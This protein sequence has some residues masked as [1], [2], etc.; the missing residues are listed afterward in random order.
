M[1]FLAIVFTLL[2]VGSLCAQEVSVALSKTQARVGETVQFSVTV[3][4]VNRIEAPTTIP[5]NGLRINFAGQSSQVQ[6]Q[7]FQMSSSATVTYLVVPQFEG[8]FTIPAFDLRIR[9][10]TLATSPIQLTVSGMASTPS[11]P[12][13]PQSAPSVPRPQGGVDESQPIYFGELIL[14]KPSAFVGEV[15]PAELRFYF[16]SGIGGQIGERPSF[17]GEGFTIEKFTQGARRDQI[18]NGVGYTVFTFKTAITA[19]KTGTLSLP[20]ATLDA[21]LQLPGQPSQD[22]FLGQFQGLIPPGMFTQSQDVALETRPTELEVRPLP[23]EGKPTDFSGAIGRFT[24]TTSAT[25]NAVAAGE[26]V[27]LRSVVAG[28]GNFSAMEPPIL[29]NTEGWKTYPPSEV[30]ETSDAVN[31][32]GKK[33]FEFTSVAREDQTVTPGVSFTFFDPSTEKY[34][35]LTNTPLPVQ[36]KGSASVLAATASPTPQANP[37]APPRVT[38]PSAAGRWTPVFS[39]QTFL[40]ANGVAALVAV[41][42]LGFALSRRFARSDAGRRAVQRQQWTRLLAKARAC[43]DATFTEVGIAYVAARCGGN[44]LAF[45]SRLPL[46][47]ESV[48]EP[49]ALLWHMHNEALYS[50]GGLK[51][52]TPE[53]RSD[54]L[55][56]L[57]EWHRIP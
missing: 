46:L 17:T 44:I 33:T 12:S 43:E 40:I 2:S 41:G 8:V 19:V 45:P 6:M 56:A 20:V 52:L 37:P 23:T 14:S 49:L 47:P 57:E 51:T 22:D 24:L 34:I 28:Q 26:P 31:F 48:Q 21:R 50:S 18:I 15:V 11:S 5:V 55:A 4:G 32:G 53:Q 9:G 30:F 29:T 25:P 36:A 16:Q 1:R 39:H 42:L 54:V 10:R 13:L 3:L 27:T 38:L 7:N 35:L